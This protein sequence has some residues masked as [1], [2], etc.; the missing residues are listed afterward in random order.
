MENITNDQ[1]TALTF[2]SIEE[3]V[4]LTS[5]NVSNITSDA[6]SSTHIITNTA[7]NIPLHVC[8]NPMQDDTLQYTSHLQP[9]SVIPTNST[10]WKELRENADSKASH[11]PTSRCFSGIH[12]SPHGI[13]QINQ[14]TISY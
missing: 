5:Q 3:N 13:N 11:I 14:M 1:H 2:S 6:S 4:L 12:I 10:K 9:T 7:I 8:E